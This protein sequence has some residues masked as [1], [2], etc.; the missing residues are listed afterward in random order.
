[1]LFFKGYAFLFQFVKMSANITYFPLSCKGQPHSG[2]LQSGVISCYVM[3]L[4]FSAL[5]SKP[6]ETSKL[7][8]ALCKFF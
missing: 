4:T 8:N 6:P 7:P 2:L 5:S 1:M 3:Y